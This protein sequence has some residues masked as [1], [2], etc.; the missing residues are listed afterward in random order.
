MKPTPSGWKLVRT[1][2]CNAPIYMDDQYDPRCFVCDLLTSD[3]VN[4]HDA[5]QISWYRLDDGIVDEW[6]DLINIMHI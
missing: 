6:S 4:P 1:H 3:H 5:N 2:A